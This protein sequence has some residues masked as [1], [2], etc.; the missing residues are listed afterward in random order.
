[1]STSQPLQSHSQPSLITPQSQPQ[2]SAKQR[3]C[4][5]D[6]VLTYWFKGDPNAKDYKAP[7]NLWLQVV[8][9]TDAEIKAQF[10]PTVTALLNNALDTSV[11]PADSPRTALAMIAVAEFARRIY[12]G[13]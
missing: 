11:W 9:Q 5:P 2:S 13:T 3:V 12:S 7:L 10:E 8:P 6:E 1:M 4:T